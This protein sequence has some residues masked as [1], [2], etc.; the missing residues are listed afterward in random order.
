MG[1]NPAGSTRGWRRWLQ[2]SLRTLLVATVVIGLGLGWF[3]S[4][5]EKARRQADAVA[6]LRRAGA[7]VVYEHELGEG[8]RE[9]NA[10]G[11]WNPDW[12]EEIEPPGPRWLREWLGVDFFARVV[13]VEISS[14]K[15]EYDRSMAALL[16]MIE[17]KRGIEP[18]PTAADT[19][20]MS[21]YL[22]DLPEVTELT[23]G[24][25]APAD[26]TITAETM[27]NIASLPQL[28][29]LNIMTLERFSHVAELDQIVYIGGP[30]CAW[31]VRLPAEA[32]RHLAG[33]TKLERL[34]LVGVEG[35]EEGL[36]EIAGLAQLKE[37]TLVAFDETE[38]ELRELTRRRPDLKVT[39][40][41]DPR[42]I[43]VGDIGLDT[44]EYQAEGVSDGS[45]S[46]AAEDRMKR[47]DE[48]REMMRNGGKKGTA[49]P[50]E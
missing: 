6:G 22:R 9:T 49:T 28:R 1:G 33:L 14:S 47:F 23:I 48:F 43:R 19:Q 12:R 34:V 5:L 42:P 17:P 36:D 46:D 11:S 40:K 31:N 41:L 29:Q 15:G 35:W 16:R 13:G 26:D 7:N 30:P 27:A 3:V 45:K 32:Q 24:P 37:L 4:R 21:G 20:M 10:D 8:R 18:A 44:S 39:S 50:A 2:F 25:F 38:D